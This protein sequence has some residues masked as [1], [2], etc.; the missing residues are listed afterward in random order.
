MHR[1]K[2][3]DEVEVEVE[4]EKGRSRMTRETEEKKESLK[5]ERVEMNLLP[6]GTLRKPIDV[7]IQDVKKIQTKVKDY[8][9]KKSDLPTY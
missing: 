5:V 3:K 8:T 4:V 2:R 1:R 6:L 7:K 9:G